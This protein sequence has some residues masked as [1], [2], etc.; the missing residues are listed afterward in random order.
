[1]DD[2]IDFEILEN[3][4]INGRIFLQFFSGDVVNRQCKIDCLNRLEGRMKLSKGNHVLWNNYNF[5]LEMARD[6][7]V[8]LVQ[9]GGPSVIVQRNE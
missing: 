1:M 3:E 6:F 8:K 7:S 2:G 5:S 4:A 9:N